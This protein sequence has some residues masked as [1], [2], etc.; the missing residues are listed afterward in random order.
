MTRLHEHSLAMW[1]WKQAAPWVPEFQF[2]AQ[3]SADPQWAC[4]YCCLFKGQHVVT[5]LRCSGHYVSYVNSHGN[6]LFFDDEDVQLQ[7]E[8][9]VQTAYG[10]AQVLPAPQ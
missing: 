3:Q 7:D 9:Q 5:Q 2:V 1:V 6:W 8:A 10:S 4:S